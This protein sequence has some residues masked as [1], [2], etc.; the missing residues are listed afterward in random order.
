[1]LKFP[2][3]ATQ[4]QVETRSYSAKDPN[5][6]QRDYGEPATLEGRVDVGLEIGIV[7]VILKHP[8]TKIGNNNRL[9]NHQ[10]LYY[11]WNVSSRGPDILAIR[12]LSP[13]SEDPYF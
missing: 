5:T 9:G 1:M 2:V 3:S 12:P 10:D 8:Q 7:L 13:E 6:A 11:A 4:L